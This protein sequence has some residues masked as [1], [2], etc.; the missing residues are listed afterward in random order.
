MRWHPNSCFD[1]AN[2]RY[3]KGRLPKYRVRF[4]DLPGTWGRCWHS[5]RLIE[6]SD[7]LRSKW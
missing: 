1:L 4:A 5:K 3:F 7:E 6:L 2:D